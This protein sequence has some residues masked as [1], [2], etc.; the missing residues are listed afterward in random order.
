MTNLD[1]KTIHFQTSLSAI[2][3]YILYK[4]RNGLGLNQRQMAKVF[5]ISHAT[6]GGMERGET[7]INA[8]FIY[9]VCSFINFKYSDYYSLI[10]DFVTELKTTTTS[11]ITNNFTISLIPSTDV[12]K[13]INNTSGGYFTLSN[14]QPNLIL[15]QDFNFFISR[16]LF[17]KLDYLSVDRLTPQQVKLLENLDTELLEEKEAEYNALNGINPLSAS[18]GAAS[19]PLGA[20]LGLQVLAGTVGAIGWGG[21]ELFKAYKKNKEDKKKK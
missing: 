5:D 15:N 10:E 16:E 7:A 2:S 14:D 18:T 21:Y 3:G 1:T 8:D 6:Y 20:A 12:I 9:M 13:I 11:G 4:I 19:A 17:L